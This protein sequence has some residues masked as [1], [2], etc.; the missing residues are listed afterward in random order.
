MVSYVIALSL[1]GS[2]CAPGSKSPLQSWTCSL[3]RILC[4]AENSY[5]ALAI[6]SSLIHKCQPEVGYTSGLADGRWFECS[7][8]ATSIFCHRSSASCALEGDHG[9]RCREWSPAKTPDV[10]QS[11]ISG[12]M[13]RLPQE[14]DCCSYDQSY[15]EASFVEFGSFLPFLCSSWLSAQVLESWCLLT[16][17]YRKRYRWFDVLIHRSSCSVCG[18]RCWLRMWS[19][20]QLHGTCQERHL[21]GPGWNASRG[22]FLSC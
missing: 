2:D 11:L 7:G 12:A 9:C 6:E 10:A 13:V 17:G 3:L 18:S 21:G 5:L 19:W 1:G 16:L 22:W 4:F 20:L 15:L 14:S 8:C